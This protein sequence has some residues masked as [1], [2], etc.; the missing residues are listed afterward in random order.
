VPLLKPQVHGDWASQAA[1]SFRYLVMTLDGKAARSGFH[2][3]LDHSQDVV[4]GA[5]PR[6]SR[7]TKP[8]RRLPTLAARPLLLR[9]LQQIGALC[10][11]ATSEP[12]F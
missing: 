8:G 7:T 6:K 12:A 2:R 11:Y 3:R 1:D 5:R 4:G 10:H 9:A